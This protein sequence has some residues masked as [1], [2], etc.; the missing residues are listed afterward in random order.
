MVGWLN[1][2]FIIINC[3]TILNLF[4]KALKI[5]SLL[6]TSQTDVE[7][8]RNINYIHPHIVCEKEQDLIKMARN[9]ICLKVAN[10]LKRQKMVYNLVTTYI[11]LMQM[12]FILISSGLFFLYLHIHCYFYLIFRF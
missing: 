9:Y 4:E 5:I 1:Q 11:C 8:G 2:I 7:C 3:F 12:C 6:T 10:I